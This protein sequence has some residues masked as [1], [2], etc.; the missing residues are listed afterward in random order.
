[1]GL[2]SDD[3][4]FTVLPYLLTMTYGLRFCFEGSE[5]EASLQTVKR[6]LNIR[7]QVRNNHIP[8]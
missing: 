3:I 8:V 2:T 4:R 5:L 6:T 1:M 7:V